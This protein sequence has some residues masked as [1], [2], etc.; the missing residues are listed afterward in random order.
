VSLRIAGVH[1]VLNAL[2]AAALAAYCQ[3]P[4]AAIGG[5]LSGFAGI[6][7]RLEIVTRGRDV[8]VIDDYAHH[9]TEIRAALASIRQMAPGRRVWCVFQPHQV[10]RTLHLF[11]SLAQSL[12][13]ADKIIVAE[14]FRAREPSCGRDEV[15]SADL[16]RRVR[17]LGSDVAAVHGIDEIQSVLEAELLPGDVVATLGAGDIGKVAHGIGKRIRENRAAV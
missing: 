7:R 9:P 6:H 2:A 13:N 15:S 8:T 4:A 16:A 12:L 5:A 11:E 1:N 14:I 17:E 10:S 3:A